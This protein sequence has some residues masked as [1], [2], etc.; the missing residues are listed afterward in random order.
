MIDKHGFMLSKISNIFIHKLEIL[1]TFV[2]LKILK[3]YL[4]KKAAI[5]KKNINA[6]KA[7][8][9]TSDYKEAK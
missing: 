9:P 3:C 4:F 5:S 6:G 8:I 2:S 7:S 1:P